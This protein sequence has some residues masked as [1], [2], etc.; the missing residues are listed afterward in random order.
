MRDFV[1]VYDVVQA[2]LLAM[3]HAGA[4][5]RAINIGSGEAVSIREVADTLA[6]AL[7]L[8]IPAELTGKY[9]AGD[10]RHCFANIS[11][12]ESLLGYRPR[13]S[14]AE[15]VTDLMNWLHSQPPQERARQAVAQI[16]EFGLT[17]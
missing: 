2:N 16:S 12:A 3:G 8:A 5:H 6:E 13:V 1:S 15:G 11:A 10:I 14:F 4:D 7:G 17:A 9:R